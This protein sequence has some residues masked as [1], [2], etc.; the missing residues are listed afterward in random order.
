MRVVGQVIA[1]MFVVG[2]GRAYAED[3]LRS[4]KEFEPPSG[5]GRAVMVGLRRA[6]PA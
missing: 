3:S 2:P 1:M 6:A 5:K 4:Q